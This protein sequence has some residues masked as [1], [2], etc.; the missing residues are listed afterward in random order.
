MTK[1]NPSTNSRIVIAGGGTAGWIA[2][3]ALAKKMGPLL[4]ITLVESAEIGTVGVGEATIPP[5][6]V[7]HKLLRIDEQA[8]MQAT[9]A[10]FK[11]GIQFENW[12]QV[13]DSYIHSFGQTGQQSWLAEFV[14]FWLEARKRGL[15]GNYGDYCLELEAALQGK[16]ATS[17][18]SDINYAYHL[19]AG[20]YA[21]FLANFCQALGV[22]RIEG[23]IEQVEQHENDFISA[24]VLTDGTRIEGDL[25]IDCTGFRGLLIEQTLHTGYEDWSHWLPCDSAVAIQTESVAPAQPF[26]R[27]IAHHAGWQWQIPLQ[28]RVG[29]GLVYSRQH[30]SDDEAREYLLSHVEGTPIT[31]PRVIHYRTGRRLKAWNKNCVALGLASGF[32]EPLEST[33][34]HL[35]IMGIT[36]LMQL[37]PFNG[38]DSALIDEYNQQTI[39]ELERIR[40]FI[41]LH[42][43]V[44]ER[45]DSPFWDYCRRMEI[46]E[47]LLHRINL[48][49]TQGHAFQKHNELF[50]VD[51]WTQVMLG[52]RLLPKHH[53]PAPALM[54]DQQL[55]Q[56]LSQHREQIL[57]LVNRLPDHQTF[58]NQYCKRS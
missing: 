53:H 49:A 25:F 26:T 27:S 51:S 24:L 22:K 11:L 23:K 35:I 36:R 47:T 42:Y 33:S 30:M 37:F 44:T 46:P 16:F 39:E 17:P 31:E 2:A 38:W 28:H 5:L 18:Q 9:S 55:S 15:A 19:D 40:D 45:N 3:A 41:V 43:H 20:D 48:F 54:T 1:E 8:F 52:Q 58:I 14:H 21:R 57:Q 10:T 29:N 50:R 13:G 32:V 6:R 34:I 7:F 56:A 4:D 12:G